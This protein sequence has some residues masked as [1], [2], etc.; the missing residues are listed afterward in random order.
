MNEFSFYLT[1]IWHMEKLKEFIKMTSYLTLIWNNCKYKKTSFNAFWLA[2]KC[3]VLT[4]NEIPGM[5]FPRLLPALKYI[6]LYFRVPTGFRAPG[7]RDSGLKTAGLR[8]AWELNGK[9]VRATHWRV[10]FVLFQFQIHQ[11][12][13]TRLWPCYN[14]HSKIHTQRNLEIEGIWWTQN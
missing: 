9:Y 1:G 11:P 4:N 6:F 7:L 8:Y 10:H 12:Q 5:A 14:P 2:K 13:S 3:S